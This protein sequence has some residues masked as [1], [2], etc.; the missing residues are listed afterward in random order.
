MTDNEWQ[1]FVSIKICLQ[2]DG[3]IPKKDIQ[4]LVDM[5]L[6][7]KRNEQKKTKGTK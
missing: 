4:F 7:L 2:R 1:E 5:V 6:K 3:G